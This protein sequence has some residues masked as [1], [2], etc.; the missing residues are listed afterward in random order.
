MTRFCGAIWVTP[1]EG[2]VRVNDVD[3]A[4]FEWKAHRHETDRV[5]LFVHATGFHAR[6]WDRTIAALE[7]G[8]RVIAL[9]LRGHGRSEKK[10]PYGWDTMGE[11]VLR[12][13]E[14]LD[15]RR[16]VGIGHSMG[17]HAMTQAVAH[18]ESRF[19]RLL[20]VDPVIMDPAIYA[21]RAT[22]PT[23][24]DAS[25][26]PTSKRK[27]DWTSWT[28]ML[29]RFSSR[30]PFT[31]WNRHV[32]EDYCRYGVLP[33][34]DGP[35]FVLACP[36]RVEASIYTGSARGDIYGAIRGIRIPVTVLRAPQ[37][38]ADAGPMDFTHS[39]TWPGLAAAFPNGR[40]VLVAHLTHF[41]PMQEPALVAAY[42]EDRA[43]R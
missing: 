15:L 43:P 6:V 40:D 26:H 29:E 12:F 21:Q 37:R 2:R 22:D 25:E 33:N 34:P 16:I 42:A 1:V 4:Y 32:L 27:N 3:L 11:D 20:L 36:P 10:G 41:I 31:L 39:P 35:G 17:G 7:G 24:S 14:A 28:E 18:A 30:H 38:T 13:V 9:E 23:W 5:L 19:E 8:D